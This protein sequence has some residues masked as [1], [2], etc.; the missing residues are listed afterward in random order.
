MKSQIW[1]LV[2]SNFDLSES[3]IRTVWCHKKSNLK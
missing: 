1:H 2:S 3:D